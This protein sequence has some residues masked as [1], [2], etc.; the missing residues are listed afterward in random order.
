MGVQRL[1]E[2]DGYQLARRQYECGATDRVVKML[3][4][5]ALKEIT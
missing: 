5:R 1:R 3:L 4:V 2:T